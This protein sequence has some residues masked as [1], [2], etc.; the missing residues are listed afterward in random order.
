MLK[1]CTVNALD[2]TLLTWK[3]LYIHTFI[4]LYTLAWRFNKHLDWI[5]SVN[6]Y[7]QKMCKKYCSPQTHRSLSL[8]LSAVM[9]SSLL[10]YRKYPN[11]SLI[12]YFSCFTACYS[13]LSLS[14]FTCSASQSISLF[15]HSSTSSFLLYQDTR[16]WG[17]ISMHVYKSLTA[18]RVVGVVF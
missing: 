17:F 13:S 7:V 14:L 9:M 12:V 11:V 18:V 8:C 3:V 5:R 15:P 4:S 16:P 10:I 1:K 6:I 2:M